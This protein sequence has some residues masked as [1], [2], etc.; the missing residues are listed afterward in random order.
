MKGWA[1]RG[2]GEGHRLGLHPWRQYAADFVLADGIATA[3][4]QELAT[5][6]ARGVAEPP[7]GGRLYV[8]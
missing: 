4:D 1:G 2:G 8:G 5:R 3:E 6:V 7:Q